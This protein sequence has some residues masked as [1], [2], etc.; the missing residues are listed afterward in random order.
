[1]ASLI[2]PPLQRLSSASSRCEQPRLIRRLGVADKLFHRRV[3]ADRHD[4]VGERRA[5]ADPTE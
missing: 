5:S 2:S 3:A 4:L 1:M